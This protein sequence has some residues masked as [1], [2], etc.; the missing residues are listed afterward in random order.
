VKTT[1]SLFRFCG[2]VAA[3]WWVIVLF[4]QADKKTAKKVVGK[5]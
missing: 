5:V 2:W 1:S 3:W 4:K